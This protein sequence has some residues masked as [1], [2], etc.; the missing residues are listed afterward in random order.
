MVSNDS[1]AVI[2]VYCSH[3]VKL[4]TRPNVSVLVT[5][6]GLNFSS[7][8]M[9]RIHLWVMQH[10]ATLPSIKST[11]KLSSFENTEG[12]TVAATY[13]RKQWALLFFTYCYHITLSSFY[14]AIGEEMNFFWNRKCF[15]LSL[16][17]FLSLSFLWLQTWGIVLHILLR[18]L[19][20]IKKLF[21]E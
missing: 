10:P 20:N 2:G 7:H 13:V 16:F 4:W 3:L 11:S 12:F 8:I 18:S 5:K 19:W 15:L 1:S 14:K 9:V 17:F 21:V 6:H